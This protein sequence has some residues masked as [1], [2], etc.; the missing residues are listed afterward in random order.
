LLSSVLSDRAQRGKERGR[1][2]RFDTDSVGAIQRARD[3]AGGDALALASTTYR[4][5][6]SL[7]PKLE[8]PG[9]VSPLKVES[10]VAATQ[11]VPLKTVSGGT[12]QRRKSRKIRTTSRDNGDHAGNGSAREE[13]PVDVKVLHMEI[14][15]AERAALAPLAAPSKKPGEELQLTRENLS[16]VVAPLKPLGC[17]SYGVVM[18]VRHVPSGRLMAM[19]KMS[20]RRIMDSGHVEHILAEKALLQQV[21]HPF[22][23]K[24]IDTFNDDNYLYVFLE[25]C[26]G[27]ELFTRLRLGTMSDASAAFYVAEVALALKSLLANQIV[28]RDIKPENIVLDA[29]GHVRLID[30]GFAKRISSRSWSICGTIEYLA[31][32]VVMGRGGGFAADWWAL[33]CMAFE[34]LTGRSPFRMPSR[35][36]PVDE[37]VVRADRKQLFRDIRDG[38]L[39]YPAT[40]S[41][42]G[43]SLCAG[44]L[45]SDPER[46]Y[47]FRDLQH[48]AFFDH[49][50][51]KRLKRKEVTP[52]WQPKL[53]GPED[54]RY[55][56]VPRDDLLRFLKTQAG[57]K[58]D[59]PFAGF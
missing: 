33:G 30:F 28:Y 54:L 34:M 26:S 38:K 25:F 19:K 48:H 7:S 12:K 27:G 46:R 32:E 59:D 41:E 21:D 13:E 6:G 8:V 58:T 1:L 10:A 51:W 31:P 29:A 3:E 47:S 17:G 43:R 4:S 56:S 24:L 49:I 16:S 37:E 18:L 23:T 55:F 11:A 22:I 53:D 57:P 45:R 50:D 9:S 42:H 2:R 39:E 14:E 5:F 52:P 36:P 15:M 35:A 44:L 40:L 20:K